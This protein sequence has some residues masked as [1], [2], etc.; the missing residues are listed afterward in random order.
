MSSKTAK[1]ISWH[2]KA[3]R[4]GA[5]TH[6]SNGEAWKHLDRCDPSFAED[7][8]NVRLGLSMNG[9][10]PFGHSA[11]PYSCWP[12]FVTPYNLTPWMCMEEGVIFLTLIILGPHNLRK[13]I[14]VYLRPLIEE[15]KMLW[16]KDGVT[17]YDVST[18]QNFQMRSALLCTINDFPAYGMLSGWSTHRK[19]SCPYCMEN[20]MA[21]TLKHGGNP[22]F[23]IVLI[24]SCL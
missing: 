5:L 4:E 9:F 3:R 13:N 8:R 17:T 15:L 24:N 11:I 7:A 2:K 10:N 14:D 19:L 20:T 21:F 1:H 12:I 23:L 22:A 18:E 6:P 16:K